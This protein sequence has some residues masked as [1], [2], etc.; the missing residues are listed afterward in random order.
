[1]LKEVIRTGAHTVDHQT[2]VK[3]VARLM[4]EKDIGCVLVQNPQKVPV[5][6]ITDRDLVLRCL[7]N[8]I[9]PEKARAQEVMT[10]AIRTV[11]EDSGI[12]ECIRMMHDARVRRLPVVDSSGK[13]VGMISFGDLLG[14]LSKELGSLVENCTHPLDEQKAAKK[15]LAA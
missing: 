11:R 6:I 15:G 3:D 10:A 2:L 13:V 9:S 12:F 1:M 4:K 8:G 7:A 5:G 14:I